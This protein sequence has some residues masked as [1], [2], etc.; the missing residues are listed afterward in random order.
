M[1]EKNAKLVMR[2]DDLSR[3]L[4]NTSRRYT[5][6]VKSA[7][8]LRANLNRAKHNAVVLRGR[9]DRRKADGI[10]A[11]M[12]VCVGVDAHWMKGDR[13]IFTE[14]SREMVRDLVGFKVA[15]MNMDGVIHTV[16]RGF[17]I[18]LQD[19]ISA[20]QV[21]RIVEEGGI[22][23]DIQVTMEIQQAE[24]FAPSGDGTTIRHL[25]FEGKHAT[26]LK[27]GVPLTRMLDITSAP[28]HTSEE[29]LAGWKST[30]QNSLVDTFNASPL[31]QENPID[32]DEFVTFI[33]ALG[34]DHAADQRKWVRLTNDWTTDAHKIMLGKRYLSSN[35]IQSYLPEITRRND[36]KIE[37]AGGLDAWNALSEEE[38]TKRDIEVCREL[39]AYYGDTQWKALSPQE[40]FD[41]EF[42]VWCGCCM[43][44]EMNSVK[45]GVQ[46]MKLFWQAIGG[47][48]PVKLMNKGNDA[49]AS[50]SAPGSKAAVHAIESS[51]GCAVK[52]TGLLGSLFNHKDDK[53]G[54]QDTFKLYFEEF[55]GYTV[56]CPDTSNNR[57]QSH[58]DCA[59]FIILYLPQILAFMM[60][61]MYSKTH[62]GLDH[63]EQNILKGLKCTST[64]TELAVLALYANA[65]S[66]PYMRVARDYVNGRRLTRGSRRVVQDW[67]P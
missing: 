18:G 65:V 66:Y 27:D 42:L 22:A 46:A 59:V 56:S 12:K 43:H 35:D 54:Q 57:F 2:A 39:W 63:L 25:N 20:R 62:I 44:K 5:R 40:R 47:P 45:G 32:N 60:H 34:S 38:R 67:Q 58:C 24:A 49:A 36:A 3:A 17:G 29:Q 4:H 10:A 37:T 28:N 48:E 51:E 64:L 30:I 52:V 19:H 26:Y 23:S 31:G 16:A 6:S 50:N 9:V 14:R 61:V 8:I 15:P 55:L 7:A 1:S 33:K 11:A 13:G 41:R 21:G 53:K